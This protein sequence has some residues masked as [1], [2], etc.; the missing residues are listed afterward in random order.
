MKRIARIFFGLIALGLLAIAIMPFAEEHA[1]ATQPMPVTVTNT[2]LSVQGTVSVGNTPTVSVAN[3]P[4]VNV[5]NTPTVNLGNSNITVS[6]SLDSGNNPIPLVVSG[7]GTPYSD[8]CSAF[9]QNT[10]PMYS[11]P[12][13]MRLVIQAVSFRSLANGGDVYES[14]LITIVNGA[15]SN[16][17][18]PLSNSGTDSAGQLHQAAHVATLLYADAGSTP[19]CEANSSV[20]DYNFDCS[21][22]GYLVSAQ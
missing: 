15:K 19:S 6:N 8:S 4:S 13:N 16:S 22:S 5:A 18:M 21:I 3:T 11:L 1:A 20:V 17:Y 7:A 10:C 2:P 14:Y 9:F 12:A